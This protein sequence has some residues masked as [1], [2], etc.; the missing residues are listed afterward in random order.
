MAWQDV[1]PLVLRSVKG[2]PLDAVDMDLNF[3]LIGQMLCDLVA[4]H[5]HDGVNSR[6]ITVNV[7]V[8][9]LD[10]ATI[11]G[12]VLRSP[13][14]G[15]NAGTEI[16]LV[17][18]TM[19]FGGSLAPKFSVNAAGVLTAVDAHLSGAITGST[20]DIGAATA[21]HADIDG[22]LWIGA[23][24]FA[25]APFSV[26]AAGALKA[27]NAEITGTITG[28][29]IRTAV[30]GAR[31]VL[32]TTGLR[33]YNQDP[34]VQTV[35][36]NVD[37]SGWIG[38]TG[39]RAIEWTTAGAVKVAGFSLDAAT[40]TVTADGKTTIVSSGTT[41]FAAGTTGSPEFS[42]SDA[43]V[44]VA[45][46]AA[47]SGAISAAT[48]DIGT[49]GDSFHVN[50]GGDLWLGAPAYADAPFRVSK[51]GALY[52]ASV[53]LTGAITA[54]S[55]TIGG[56][57]VHNVDGL[58]AGSGMSRVQLKI[59]AGLWAGADAF[60]DAPFRVSTAGALVATGATIAGAIT[61]T[62]GAIGGWTIDAT[63]GLYAGAAETLIKLKVGTG[64]WAGGAEF[65]TAPFS[66]SPAG[67]LVAS[68][69][70]IEGAITA[71]SGSFTGTVNATDGTFTGL[72]SGGQFVG[73]SFATG[74][75]VDI[76]HPG[77][78][79]DVLG[80]R[81]YANV[82]GQGMVETF[83]LPVN[84]D[85]PTFYKG[86]VKETQIELYTSGLIKTAV[87]ALIGA[88][89]TAGVVITPAGIFAGEAGQDTSNA[90]FRVTYDG[91]LNAVGVNR[92]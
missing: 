10:D 33:A 20:I 27:L 40:M 86:I 28:S 87:D 83:N 60:G 92:H 78:I 7:V 38:L 22:N 80:I 9:N 26:S 58:Y 81:G 68:N 91:F 62:S 1:L 15:A 65:A 17:N 39:A 73:G 89:G 55:G 67:A 50:I 13:D 3:T 8:D 51:A 14:W 61:A 49:G 30:S 36:I 53:D 29:T 23:A 56:W 19:R 48:I 69:A 16:D 52:A 88:G 82:G 4:G 74:E 37:G 70:T 32:D 24:T 18:K 2:E 42:V 64:L 21:L 76:M 31:V 63:E 59:G 47:I 57:T 41:A 66:V 25:S 72:I 75:D 12:G 46:N 44:L 34:G 79:V 77:V 11:T 84:G 43:G 6:E 5:D 54:T 85:P 45:T 90:N 71:T 35:D